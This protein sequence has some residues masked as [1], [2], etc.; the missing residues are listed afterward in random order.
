M[1]TVLD[2]T[3]DERA[4]PARERLR[5]TTAAV[6]VSF[7]WFGTRKTLTPQQK[8]QAAD[9]F[10][11]EGTFLSAGKKLIDT[12]HPAFKAVTGVRGRIVAYWRGIS[13]PYPEPGIRLIRQED[14]GAV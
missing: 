4:A 10:G 8:A 3:V 7:T 1:T 12:K 9:A 6:R 13:L 2:E 14:I 11:A 5:A